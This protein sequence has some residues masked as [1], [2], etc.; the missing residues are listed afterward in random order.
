MELTTDL[1]HAVRLLLRSPLFTL[2]SVISLALGIGAAATIFSLTDALMFEPTAGVR[3]P[4]EL[5]DIGRANEG[6]GFDNMSHPAYQYL[7]DHSQTTDVAAV[8]FGGGPMSLGTT[9]T[10]ER[11]IGTLVSGNYFDVLQTRPAVGRFFRADEDQVPGERPVVV[12]SHALWAK[13]FNSD[14]AILEKP[15]RLNNREFSVVGVAEP[16]FLGSSMVGT[17]LWV[18]MAM[19]QVARGEPNANM[20]T[21]VRGVWH[22]AVGRMKPG[23]STAQ[24]KAELNTLMAAYKK[25]QPQANQEH[26]IAVAPMGRI[27]GPFRTPFLAFIGF[28]FAL[29]GSLLAIACSN[30][31]GMLLARAATRRREMATRL[32]VGASRGR[33]IA[34]LLTET[35]VLFA[36]AAGVSVPLTFWLVSLLAGALPALPLSLNLDFTVNLRVMAFAFGIA[37]MTGLIFGLAPARHA[38]GADLAP[39]LHGANAT[40]D[41]KRFRLRNTLVAAQVALSLMLVVTAAL[42]LRSLERAAYTDPGFKTANIQI[43]TVDVSLSGYRE[44]QA[45]DIANRFKE[46]LRAVPGVESVATAR[47]IPLQGSGFG[48]GSIRVPGVA[49]PFRDGRFNADWDIVSPEYFDTIGMPIVEGRGFLESDHAGSQRVTVISETM[50]RQIWPGQSAIGRSFFQQDSDTEER[51]FQVVGVARDAKYRYISSPPA[52]FIYVAMAQVPTSNLEL[53]I[54][55]AP[56]AHVA[57]D[58]RA[59]MAHVEPNVPLVMLQSFDDA[60]AIGLLPQKL[61]AVIA[62]SV[63]TIGIFLAALGLYGLMAFLVAQRT[64]EIAIRMALGASSGEMRTMVL[65]QAAMLASIGGAVGLLLAA[66]IGTLARVLLGNVPPIDPLSFGGTALL[67]LVVLAVAAW[68]PAS[69]AAATDP[70]MALRAE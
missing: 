42:F 16:G 57:A 11:V 59:A 14:P 10:S 56:G 5:I 66:G 48:L 26:T 30:V 13:R 52:P 61:A 15:L 27:P 20:L 37:L 53:Y 41:R 28:L 22:L 65:R 33:L 21:E 36:V 2:T 40:A 25:E 39:M 12:I 1:R 63:G 51:Q 34:Q 50:A 35:M 7:H 60:A 64:R 58:V 19:V 70:A 6:S 31:A 47:M 18:P 43:A 69:R 68:T 9:G 8:D 23:V 38:L 3:D 32:A 46:R 67:F 62:G 24:A 44:Q 29:T 45:V 17:D 49:G 4:S 55:H 54:R